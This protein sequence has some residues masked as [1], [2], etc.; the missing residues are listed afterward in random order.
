LNIE[1][2]KQVKPSEKDVES[3][4]I[5]L[6][7][8]ALKELVS[9][10]GEVNIKLRLDITDRIRKLNK[11]QS[12]LVTVINDNNTF[13]TFV[14]NNQ[15]R[16]FDRAGNRYILDTS[17]AI[18]NPE[19]RLLHMHY[20]YGNPFPIEF[21]KTKLPEATPDGQ[22]LKKTMH[23]EYLQALAQVTRFSKR[24]DIA[25]VFSI[26]SFIISAV[27]LVLYAHQSGMF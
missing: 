14:M 13:D 20:F 25:M 5:S 7:K 11:K 22:L 2:K 15:K 10:T 9:M 23:F 19:F 24:V 26:L 3:Y 8:M 6:D 4:K 16:T 12:C 27:H 17:K 21:V 18:F 1:G